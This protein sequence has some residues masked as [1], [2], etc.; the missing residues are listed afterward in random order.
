MPYL[1]ELHFLSFAARSS[2]DGDVV[3][4]VSSLAVNCR[5][6]LSTATLL[7][8]I[9]SRS[10][11]IGSNRG[12]QCKVLW[13][14]R[15]LPTQENQCNNEYLGWN[16]SKEQCSFWFSFWMFGSAISLQPHIHFIDT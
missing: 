10:S 16:T 14:P 5:R 9:Q 3:L 8:T 13:R 6:M 12:G 7:S 4:L 1:P 2:S 11:N 15:L